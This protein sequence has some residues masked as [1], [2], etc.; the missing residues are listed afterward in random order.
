MASAK[1]IL[2]ARLRSLSGN[3]PAAIE[4]KII[5]SIPKTISN[6]VSVTIAA[7]TS[8]FENN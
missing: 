1:P 3:F 8:G 6:K 5:L 4:I 7:Q 2:V